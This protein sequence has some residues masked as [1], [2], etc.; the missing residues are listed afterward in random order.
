MP[1]CVCMPGAFGGQKRVLNPLGTEV[2]GRCELWGQEP[3]PGPMEE[4]PVLF[5]EFYSF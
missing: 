2:I 1:V 3:N 5:T 4:Q